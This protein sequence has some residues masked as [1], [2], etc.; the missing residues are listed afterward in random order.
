GQH[1][2]EQLFTLEQAQASVSF[3]GFARPPVLSIN[4]GFSAPVAIEREAALEDLV[5]LAA[6]DDD[7]FAP[8][9]SM[10]DLMVG[11]LRDA[12]S[13][14]LGEAGRAA[15]CEAIRA[16]FAAVLADATLDDLM[17]GELMIL[18]GQAYLSEQM[19][20]ADPAAIH[21]EREWLKG[22]LGAEL[23]TELIA[24]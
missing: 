14:A 11:H 21:A 6:H 12:A 17:R 8:Y 3:A 13:G 15:G 4:R 2:G 10:Q 18:P 1:R 5:F 9:E 19:P 20:V 7:P 16:A 22:W 24:L 23:E